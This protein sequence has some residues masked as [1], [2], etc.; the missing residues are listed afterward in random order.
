MLTSIQNERIKKYKKLIQRKYRKA[1]RMFLIEGTHLLEEA[2]YANWEI[3]EILYGNDVILPEGTDEIQTTLVSEEVLRHLAQT[4]TPQKII[5][6]VK[7]RE[8]KELLGERVLLLDQ[9]QD[10]GNVGTIIRSAAAFGYDTVYLGK[11]T[12]DLYNEKV[13]RATQGA[14]FHLTIVEVDLAIEIPKL[15]EAGFDVWATA[16]E[17]AKELARVQIKKIEK[18]A[19]LLG[20]E[21]SGIQTKLMDLATNRVTIPLKPAAESLNVA[22]AA[23]IIMYETRT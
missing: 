11:G 5:A 23:G 7:Q 20:N 19:L 2:L 3:P 22:I 4:E 21:G 6:V 12:V 10:P 9:L 8:D 14:F 18:L 13:L 16:L 15:V 17:D 1:E